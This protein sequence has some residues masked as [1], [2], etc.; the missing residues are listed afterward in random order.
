MLL[1]TTYKVGALATNCYLIQDNDTKK[2]V[3]I[4][5][6]GI[7]ASLD[8]KIRDLGS[9]NF[10]YIILTHGHFD[11]VRKV[12]RY[13]D[14]TNAKVV[15]NKK[16]V[17]FVLDKSLNLSCDFGTRA[18]GQFSVDLSL[19]DGDIINLGK[20]QIK[21]IHTPGHTKGGACYIVDNHLFT[22]DTL[23]KNTMG[24]TDLKSG[25]IKEMSDSLK[26]LAA[27]KENYIVYPGHGEVSS[28]DCEKKNNPYLR[29][30]LNDSIY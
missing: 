28:L 24:R 15:M 7:S 19:D 11:H 14:L 8:E 1:V 20:T 26:R 21:M 18:F 10:A 25:N 17:D 9:E 22:G 2:M 29:K 23:M 4:D 6:G 12:K 16:E 3:I 30:A 13:K 27:L 5:P